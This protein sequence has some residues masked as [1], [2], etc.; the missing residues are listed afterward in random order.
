LGFGLRQPR[1][2]VLG[3]LLGATGVRVRLWARGRAGRFT[4]R[5]LFVCGVGHRSRTYPGAPPDPV[6]GD[7]LVTSRTCMSPK[8]TDLLARRGPASPCHRALV[9][10]RDRCYTWA[11]AELK[12]A[13]IHGH[14]MAYRV[15]G[16]EGPT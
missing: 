15:V 2:G 3:G 14:R 11:M 8:S 1:F 9:R 16:E 12:H 6:L 10:S 7:L 5:G 13:E 4:S